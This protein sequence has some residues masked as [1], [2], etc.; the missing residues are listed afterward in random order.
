MSGSRRGS[1]TQ[2][3]DATGEGLITEDGDGV[4]VVSA[5]DCSSRLVNALRGR[6]IPPGEPV[7]V[8]FD[9]DLTN[10]AIN[11]DLA[12]SISLAA[13]AGPMAVRSFAAP[14]APKKAAKKPAP[15]KKAAKAP[16][17]TAKKKS[18][19]KKVA[20]KKSRKQPRK[21]APKRRRP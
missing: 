15:K 9:L 14:K 10:H 6:A 16:A 13:S 4:H 3:D 11:V 18:A 5:S 8:T 20:A 17:R 1:I 21:S 2:W 7:A 12:E 19:S